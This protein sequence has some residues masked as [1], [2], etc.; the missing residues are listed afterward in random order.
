L[1]SVK[2]D[3]NMYFIFNIYFEND[4]FMDHFKEFYKP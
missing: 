4:N 2:F 3:N 1:D